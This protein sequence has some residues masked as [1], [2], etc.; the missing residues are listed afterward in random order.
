MAHQYF[1]KLSSYTIEMPGLGQVGATMGI[2]HD[3]A[4]GHYT[5]IVE[6]YFQDLSAALPALEAYLTPLFPLHR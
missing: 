5:L 1:A 6:R 2:T 4:T 3:P